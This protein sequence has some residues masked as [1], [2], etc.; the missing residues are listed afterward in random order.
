M[1][2]FLA[3]K[4]AERRKFFKEKLESKGVNIKFIK[5]S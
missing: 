2:S 3:P 4:G 5:V 1:S